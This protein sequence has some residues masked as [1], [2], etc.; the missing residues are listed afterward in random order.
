MS[1]SRW[2]KDGAEEAW[3]NIQEGQR[4]GKRLDRLWTWYEAHTTKRREQQIRAY[5]AAYGCLYN[6]FR[7][8][9]QRHCL[10]IVG[11]EAAEDVVQQTL[12]KARE[13]MPHF[14]GLRGVSSL[15]KWIYTIARHFSIKEQKR[16]KILIQLGKEIER[17]PVP[18]PTSSGA[19]RARRPHVGYEE[20]ADEEALRRDIEKLTGKNH[21]SIVLMHMHPHITCEDIAIFLD[22]SPAAVQQALYRARRRLDTLWR[23]EHGQDTVRD[24]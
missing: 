4:V 20:W 8:E 7:A 2:D 10:R 22:M 17:L 14:K 3:R 12:L 15:R 16:R 18:P 9:L 5:N 23:Q 6:V 11:P 21:R 1:E 24:V 19:W 13:A